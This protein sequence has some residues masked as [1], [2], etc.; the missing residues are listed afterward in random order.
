MAN[1]NKVILMGRLTFDPE[2]RQV[3]NSVFCK[4]SIAINREVRGFKD[5]EEHTE[6]TFVEIESWGK[7]ASAAGQYLQKGSPVYVSGRL[8]NSEWIDNQTNQKRQKLSVVAEMIQFL[9][10]GQQQEAPP[11]HRQAPPVHSQQQPT[12]EQL[13]QQYYAS[14][15]YPPQ[16]WDQSQQQPQYNN[17]NQPPQYN[18]QQQTNSQNWAIA[19]TVPF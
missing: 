9:G 17:Q 4:F 12:Q 16:F 11:V 8:K 10:G 2:V 1:E 18:N 3:N 14:R 13:V 5:T 7:V 6:V 19:G 15:Q